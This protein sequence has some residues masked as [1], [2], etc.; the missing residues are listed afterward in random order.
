MTSVARTSSRALIL[1]L[2]AVNASCGGR[3]DGS[4]TPPQTP[5]GN[6]AD[7][8]HIHGLGV[9]DGNVYIATHY[10]LWVAPSGQLKAR[11]FGDSRQDIMGFSLVA[12]RRFLGS[13]HPAP[14]DSGQ[15]PNLGLIES[16][17][18]G[19]TW[20][21]V[22]LLGEADFH[23]LEAS[24]TQVYGVNSADGQLMASSDGGRAWD[25]RTPPAGVF[26]LAI[27]PREPEQIVASTEK[28]VFA[29][30]N[31]G[32]GW[33]PL[34]D[35]I[36]GLLAWP[37]PDA[38]Y[39]L[40]GEGGI[41]LSRN[42]GRDWKGTGNIGGQPAAFIA[43]GDELYAALHDGTVKVSTDRGRTWSLRAKR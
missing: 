27:D 22:S 3:D 10:G 39:L 1:A 26:G 40:D 38:L 8:A 2:A 34:R 12:G 28:G 6:G 18:G 43:N 21:N 37:R 19:R 29:S 7:L 20:K 42:G 11:R 15:P 31:A 13:G 4:G 16:R 9:R 24:G 14:G 32:R 33:R 36:G 17:D 41:Q 5:A 25:R 23:V 30:L 35:D